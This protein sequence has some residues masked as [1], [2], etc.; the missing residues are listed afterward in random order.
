MAGLSVETPQGV[1]E[2]ARIGTLIERDETGAVNTRSITPEEAKETL[3]EE[4]AEAFIEPEAE[5]P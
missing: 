1:F 3:D 2:T 5:T 4:A